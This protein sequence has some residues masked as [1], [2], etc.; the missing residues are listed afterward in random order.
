MIENISIE[1][2]FILFKERWPERMDK[3]RISLSKVKNR[4]LAEE[5]NAFCDIPLVRSSMMD[6]VAVKS[7]YWEFGYPDTKNWVLGNEFIRA[8]TG[9]DFLDDYGAV[10]R[11]EDVEI[12]KGGGGL[13]LRKKEKVQKGQNI[14]GKGSSIS[15]GS[16]LV[17]R[18]VKLIPGDFAALAMGN[19][20]E[21]LVYKKPVVSFLPTGSELIQPGEDLKRG[22]NIDSNSVLAKGLLEDFGA[23]VKLYPIS[24]DDLSSIED[25]L[26]DALKHSD[27]IL[28]NGGSS[29]GEE[30]LGIRLLEKRATLLFHWT[31]TA[32]GRPCA[33]G[34]IE[35][36]PVVIVPGPSF[37]CFNVIQ[38]L[39]R[40][41][42]MYWTGHKE[43][44]YYKVKAE[45]V[46][47]FEGVSS[48][49]FLVGA[50]V[51]EDKEGNKFVRLMNFKKE[52]SHNCF[53]ANGFVY[54]KIGGVPWKKGDL[55]E[56]ILTR[57][58]IPRI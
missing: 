11:I 46:E 53:M 34:K 7:K 22:K 47:D 36:K 20:S 25:K 24:K 30:D 3:E 42:L 52:G 58:Y 48:V 31:M 4:V 39:I 26:N 18:G 32:P 15:K 35:G 9:D 23:E 40:P 27:F 14:R 6:G 33:M 21:V 45:L 38:W 57:P 50:K 1:E 12:G 2:A 51:S 28:I 54:T 37:G 17:K 43:D 5:Y 8:D 29:K 55:L 19:I 10:I 13:T 41:C 49:H 16:P 56:I 44:A